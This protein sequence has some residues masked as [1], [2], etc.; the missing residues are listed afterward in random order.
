MADWTK[1]GLGPA[2]TGPMGPIK[3]STLAAVFAFQE[4]IHL[5]ARSSGGEVIVHG[6]GS[7]TENHWTAT[8]KDAP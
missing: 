7:I 1:H 5:S 4:R 3:P 8:V 6:D 2:M